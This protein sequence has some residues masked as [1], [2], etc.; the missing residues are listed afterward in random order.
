MAEYD[1]ETDDEDTT[2]VVNCMC[3]YNEENDLMIQ[4]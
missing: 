3:G 1:E 2:E 4:V